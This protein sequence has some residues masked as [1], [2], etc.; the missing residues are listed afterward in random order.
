MTYEELNKML[1]ERA[2]E[3]N[4]DSELVVELD[5][6]Y[7]HEK[8]YT[9]AIEVCTMCYNYEGI[10][11]CWF[12]DWYEGQQDIKVGCIFRLKTLVDLYHQCFNK[13]TDAIYG[14]VS[15]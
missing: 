1:I 12:N 3:E 9:H 2:L 7:S 14:R 4:I 15:K 13:V 11:I 8:D 10:S 6:K 5:Y